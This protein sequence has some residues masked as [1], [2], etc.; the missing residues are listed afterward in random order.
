MNKSDKSSS[1][2]L[3][4]KAE[5]ILVCEEELENTMKLLE[6]VSKLSTE[7]QGFYYYQYQYHLT[8]SNSS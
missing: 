3:R 4:T 6:Q 1:L 8:N 7:I 5:L 2:S